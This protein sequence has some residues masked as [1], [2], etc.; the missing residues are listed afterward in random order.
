VP[1]GCEILELGAGT[2]RITHPLLAL[3]HDVVA[4]DN[5]EEMLALIRG[6]KTVSQT[7]RRSRSAGAFLSS[8]SRA[9]SSTTLTARTGAPVSSTARGSQRD[10]A[11]STSWSEHGHVRSRLRSFEHDG[12]LV[13]G[14]ME[15]VVEGQHLFHAF[16]SKLL[17]SEELDEDLRAVGLRREQELDG[18][19]SWIEAVPVRS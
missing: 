8:C 13:T 4:V 14:E 11:P 5:S 16:A 9:T 6:A 3:G 1:A 10:W 17:S 7:W 15:Y 12:D 19:G 18:R 2:G